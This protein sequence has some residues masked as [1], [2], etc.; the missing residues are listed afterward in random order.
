MSVTKYELKFIEL[1]KYGTTMFPTERQ[2]SERFERGLRIPILTQVASHRERVFY[3]L[4]ER[5]RAA[6]EVEIVM[7]ERA[8]KETE[9]SR[10]P[11][12]SSS[13]SGAFRLGKKT[14]TFIAQQTPYHFRSS[15]QTVSSYFGVSL[16]VDPYLHVRFVAVNTLGSVEGMLALASSV[17]R[18]STL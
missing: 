6:E 1:N 13:Q 11:S 3:E 16:M 4:V 9:C 5:A 10:R 7:K 15:V 17:G 8:K 14:R 2:M 12:G 18:Q